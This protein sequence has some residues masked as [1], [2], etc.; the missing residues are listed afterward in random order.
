MLQMLPAFIVFVPQAV[1]FQI[2][3]V[4]SFR[5]RQNVFN[6]FLRDQAH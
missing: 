4:V 6:V 5:P 3:S 2:V 1:F